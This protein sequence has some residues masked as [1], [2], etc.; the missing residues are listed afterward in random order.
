[1][2]GAA[3]GGEGLR[4]NKWVTVQDRTPALCVF[5]QQGDGVVFDAV[6]QC[7]AHEDQG[8]TYGRFISVGMTVSS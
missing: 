6:L 5:V 4:S 3:L 2:S 1:M 7:W 8:L